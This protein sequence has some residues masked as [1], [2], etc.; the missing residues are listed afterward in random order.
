M[1][2]RVLYAPHPPQFSVEL[3]LEQLAQLDG[4][5]ADVRQ[6]RA[7]GVLDLTVQDSAD[8]QEAHLSVRG[9]RCEWRGTPGQLDENG[10]CG[11]RR[12]F[13][14]WS[15]AALAYGLGLDLARPVVQ[16]LSRSE[17]CARLDGWRVGI[18]YAFRRG[19]DALP[20][21]LARRLNLA[22]FFDRLECEV[23]AQ[24]GFADFAVVRVHRLGAGGS[25]QVWRAEA[26]PAAVDLD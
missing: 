10:R 17:L 21:T 19:P 3:T 14:G 7:R 4:R 15:E 22:N 24:L 12:P 2:L 5:F 6:L 23:L 16:P 1:P 18:L 26:L 13:A 25:Q 8:L 11:C 20:P 9:E